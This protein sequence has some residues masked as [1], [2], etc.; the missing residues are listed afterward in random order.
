MEVG[1]I[2]IGVLS[3][4][5]ADVLF[6]KISLDTQ[7]MN[8]AFRHKLMLVVVGLYLIQVVAYTYVF[9]NHVQLSTVSIIQTALYVIALTASG[10]YFFF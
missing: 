7:S 3:I 10:L 1:V 2:G 4:V 6:K 9:I 5:I 8:N